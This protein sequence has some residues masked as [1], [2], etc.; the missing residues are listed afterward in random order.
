MECAVHAVLSAVISV[1]CFMLQRSFGGWGR[2]A[3]VLSTA[4]CHS[5]LPGGAAAYL[6]SSGQDTQGGET[7]GTVASWWKISS[8][9]YRRNSQSRWWLFPRCTSM[10]AGDLRKEWKTQ[11]E[12]KSSY[13][14]SRCSFLEGLGATGDCFIYGHVVTDPSLLPSQRKTFTVSQ[15]FLVDF[16]FCLWL[17]GFLPFFFFWEKKSPKHGIILANHLSTHSLLWHVSPPDS[18][19]LR[20]TK[21]SPLFRSWKGRRNFVNGNDLLC[22]FT[23]NNSFSL[24]F[25]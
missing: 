5:I 13:S 12:R 8:W 2:V 15:H 14:P 9:D 6:M 24:L 19:P 3:L 1:G 16:H 23:P 7:E 25:I 21:R 4:T 18:F 11:L 20:N 10:G 22:F 17:W